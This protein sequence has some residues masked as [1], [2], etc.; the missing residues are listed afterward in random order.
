MAERLTPRTL[1][2]E[3]RGSSLARRRVVSLDKKLYSTL[4]LFTQVHK[5]V[6]ASYCWEVT[7]RWTSI[8]SRGGVAMLIG[9]LHSTETG[10][11]LLPCGPLAR[12]R[13]YLTSI[14]FFMSTTIETGIRKHMIPNVFYDVRNESVFIHVTGKGKREMAGKIDHEAILFLLPFAFCRKRI[15]ST[16][17][18]FPFFSFLLK[19]L[20]AFMAIPWE[21]LA[22]TEFY[23]LN[24]P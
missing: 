4:S 3:V 5:W 22:T 24:Q 15:Y 12:V 7:L 6:P 16:V 14:N 17:S 23:F 13:L 19:V 18:F 2:L 9:L 10:N 21:S 11:K 1:D 20:L 8:P